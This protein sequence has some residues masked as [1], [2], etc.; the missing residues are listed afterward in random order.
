M[1]KIIQIS[2]TPETENDYA[3]MF[4]L[5]TDGSA[6]IWAKGTWTRIDDIPQDEEES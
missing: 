2:A 6:W 1:R 4:A 5:C 3:A